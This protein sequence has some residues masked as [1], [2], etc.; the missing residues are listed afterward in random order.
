MKDLVKAT[1][2]ASRA[3]QFDA[4]TLAG[5]VPDE[6]LPSYSHQVLPKSLYK[7]TRGYIEKVAN[8]V[9]GCYEKGWFDAAAVMAR[10]LLE[11]LIIECF[12]KHNIA[13]KIKNSNGDFY[14]LRDL[15]GLF[16]GETTWNVGRNTKRALPRLKDIGDKSAHSRRY[17][18]RR[19]DLDKVRVE[20][21]DV[22]EELL[23]IGGLK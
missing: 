18:A 4:T 19:S 14:H 20:L 10:R 1:L 13:A 5:S 3:A 12:E 15:V 7:N 17:T 16:L 2:E 8:Q 21:R 6:G 22:T 11:T 9:N 23:Y